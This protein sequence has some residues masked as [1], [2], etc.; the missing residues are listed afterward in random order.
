[1]LIALI[2]S[3]FFYL[4]SITSYYIFYLMQRF[5]LPTRQRK[6]ICSSSLPRLRPVHSSAAP[7]GIGWPQDGHLG[8]NPRRPAVYACAA[9]CRPDGNNPP[10]R[11]HRPRALVGI[12]GDSCLCPGADAR[13]GR[14]GFGPV[15]WPRFRNGRRRRRRAGRVA[16][17]TSIEFVYRVCSFLPMIGLL[18]VFLPNVEGGAARD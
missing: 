10:Q 5:D 13:P 6:S 18:T 14:H 3:K 17:W 1:M 15:L 2:F 9:L 16:D 12:L 8:F 11:A 7:S 4:A